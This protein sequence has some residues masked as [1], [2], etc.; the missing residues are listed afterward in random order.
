VVSARIIP[1]SALAHT[2]PGSG[3]AD[4]WDCIGHAYCLTLS[5]RPDRQREVLRQI[6]QLGLTRKTSF[7]ISEP[8]NGPKPPAI[9]A[10]H[11]QAARDARQQGHREVLIMEDDA[12]FLPC[13]GQ[14][15]QRIR[16]AMEELPAAWQGLYLGHFPLRAYFHGR[17]MLRAVSGCSHAYIASP[18]LLDWLAGLDPYADLPAGRIKLHR[19]VGQGID[20][21]LACRPH[22]YACFPMLATQG[23]SPSSNINPVFNRHGQRRGL[24]DKYR[25]SALLI[26]HMRLAEGI[27]A[28][29]SP[30]HRATREHWLPEKA[31]PD[32]SR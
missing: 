3:D 27:A 29:L 12:T 7:I 30:L 4:G 25:Y 6:E 18:V 8:T 28:L 26:R 23:R 14:I 2:A 5:T 21:A 22:M 31:E 19:L 20:A 32:A 1:A 11:C 13:P 16:Q 24:F 15:P 9:F 10:S 17:G